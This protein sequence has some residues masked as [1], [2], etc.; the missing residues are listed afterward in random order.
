MLLK[1]YSHSMLSFQGEIKPSIDDIFGAEEPGR[2]REQN[3]SFIE[4]ARHRLWDVICIAGWQHPGA[5]WIF[6]GNLFMVY[7]ATMTLSINQYS[8][9]LTMF[10]EA[11]AIYLCDLFL[12]VYGIVGPMLA[13]S[14]G[15]FFDKSGDE[16]SLLFGNGTVVIFVILVVIPSVASQTIAMIVFGFANTYFWM[17]IL[18]FCQL[19]AP[20]ELFG[21]FQGGY[22]FVIG[23]CQIVFATVVGDL[24]SV[25][26]SQGT[27]WQYSSQFLFWCAGVLLTAFLMAW[28]VCF[29]QPLKKPGVATMVELRDVQSQRGLLLDVQSCVEKSEP[30]RLS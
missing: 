2:K 1:K 19:Y 21:T 10:S 30:A 4:F 3:Q 27:Y 15:V 24:A 28:W 14:M 13:L 9:Y 22:A 11:E 17:I 8:Y 7:M 25:I 20:P 18:R 26:F 5:V 29:K 6:F 12:I 23:V 16:L